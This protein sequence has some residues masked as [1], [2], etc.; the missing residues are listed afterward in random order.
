MLW[1]A[2]AGLRGG[3][4]LEAYHSNNP[5]LSVA[6][7]VLGLRFARPEASRRHFFYALSRQPYLRLCRCGDFGFV[8]RHRPAEHRIPDVSAAPTLRRHFS[9]PV[10]AGVYNSPED[11][12]ASQYVCSC[13][14]ATL[15]SHGSCFGSDSSS[16]SSSGG[17]GVRGGLVLSHRRWSLKIPTV[18]FEVQYRGYSCQ[19]RLRWSHAVQMENVPRSTTRDYKFVRGQGGSLYSRITDGD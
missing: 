12:A 15:S 5:S 14:A 11:V 16:T 13:G 4:K 10:A 18:N 8:S 2:P 3:M 9:R 7:C 1:L 6:L 19:C 17:A